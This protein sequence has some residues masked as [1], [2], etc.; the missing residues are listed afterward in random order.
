MTSAS[1]LIRKAAKAKTKAEAKRL[2]AQAAKLRREARERAKGVSATTAIGADPNANR[3]GRQ[4]ASII[5]GPVN[6]ENSAQNAVFPGER[7]MSMAPF[8]PMVERAESLL[9]LARHKA[10]TAD[11]IRH[12]LNRIANN[13][14]HDVRKET[15]QRHM[16]QMKRIHEQNAINVVCAFMAE[17]EGMATENKGPLPKT[18]VVSGFTMARVIDALTKAGYSADGLKSMSRFAADQRMTR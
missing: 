7:A 14:A 11:T 6:V 8:D 9:K 1:T 10:T 5:G 4:H 12:E 2:R 3:I 18:I 17:C 13:A 16:D 15:D